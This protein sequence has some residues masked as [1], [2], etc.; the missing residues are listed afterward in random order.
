MIKDRHAPL[1]LLVEDK[2]A[3]SVISNRISHGNLKQ[4]AKKKNSNNWFLSSTTW[5]W[6]QECHRSTGE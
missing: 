3:W 1:M 2:K 6:I 5:T 4:D